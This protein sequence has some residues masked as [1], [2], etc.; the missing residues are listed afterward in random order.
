M[1]ERLETVSGPTKV[2]GSRRRGPGN[3]PV[4]RHR[5]AMVLIRQVDLLNP[6]PRPRGFVFKARTWTDY[7]QW[8]HAQSNPRLW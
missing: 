5:R 6:F 2:A 3:D 4:E 8:R 7:E 1:N